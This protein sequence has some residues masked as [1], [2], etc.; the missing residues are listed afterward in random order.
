MRNVSNEAWKKIEPRE[1]E[2]E[3]GIVYAM[4][5]EISREKEG[6]EPLLLPNNKKNQ[7]NSF[8]QEVRIN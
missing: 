1:Y 7:R 2:L 3:N 6:K 4:V 8:F 5:Y